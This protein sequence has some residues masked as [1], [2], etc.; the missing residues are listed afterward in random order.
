MKYVPVAL[1]AAIAIALVVFAVRANYPEMGVRAIDPGSTPMETGSEF[2][3]RVEG[4]SGFDGKPIRG[5]FCITDKSRDAMDFESIPNGTRVRIIAD[6][7]GPPHDSPTDPAYR[8]REV[9]ILV[10]EGACKDRTT[11]IPRS[12]LRPMPR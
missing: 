4:I 8:W 9:E 5:H 2:M 6:R 11:T 12:W 7:I 1:V 3:V 10:L